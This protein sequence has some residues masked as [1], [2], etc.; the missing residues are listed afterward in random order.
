MAIL[1]RMIAMNQIK[2]AKKIVANFQL[3]VEVLVSCIEHIN[4]ST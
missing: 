2:P 3:S 1:K 4:G